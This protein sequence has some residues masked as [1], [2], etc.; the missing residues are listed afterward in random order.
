[1]EQPSSADEDRVITVCVHRGTARD[2]QNHAC[3]IVGCQR[4]VNLQR[5]ALADGNELVVQRLRETVDDVVRQSGI[6]D[7]TTPGNSA[8]S[9]QQGGYS[10]TNQGWVC[11]VC[12]RACCHDVD[13][14]TGQGMV[15]DAYRRSREASVSQSSGQ[16]VLP[17]VGPVV[18]LGERNQPVGS[19]RRKS[20]PTKLASA[21]V[22][23]NRQLKKS[24]EYERP[25]SSKSSGASGP[26][27]L[28]TD[29]DSDGAEPGG[30]Q[31]L[32][33]WKQSRRKW[34]QSHGL[35]QDEDFDYIKGEFKSKK[36]M[37]NNLNSYPRNVYKN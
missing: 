30:Q 13:L 10:I 29:S 26:I 23:V 33:Y 32:D 14:S 3:K 5:G 17:E 8:H 31:Y 16:P 11:S 28:V 6:D 36:N 12:G 24:V 15:L 1:M 19:R 4:G 21:N 2:R 22:T 18:T 34:S 25:W 35:K 7:G 9:V 27:D 20:I 37:S